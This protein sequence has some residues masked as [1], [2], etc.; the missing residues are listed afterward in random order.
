MAL[1][2]LRWTAEQRTGAG[3]LVLGAEGTFGLDAM[4]VAGIPLPTAT[5]LELATAFGAA[6]EVIAPFGL[7]LEPPRVTKTTGRPGGAGDAAQA[8]AG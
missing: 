7:R 8:G 5:P 4:T 1:R 6:N 3:G 2:G